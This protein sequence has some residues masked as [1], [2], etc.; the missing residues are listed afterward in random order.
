MTATVAALH[1]DIFARFEADNSMYSITKSTP[2]TVKEKGIFSPLWSRIHSHPNGIPE[3]ITPGSTISTNQETAVPSESTST[4]TSSITTA[5][6]VIRNFPIQ[7]KAAAFSGSDD[8]DTRGYIVFLIVFIIA[9]LALFAVLSNINSETI[10]CGITEEEDQNNDVD[11]EN[12]G[13]DGVFVS[14]IPSF[15]MEPSQAFYFPGY[16]KQLSV[17]REVSQEFDF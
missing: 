2:A 8:A 5:S 15:N 16:K 9:M 10:G 11:I 14:D 13:Y 3:A 7:I 1:P 4:D 6:V 17:V 12:N